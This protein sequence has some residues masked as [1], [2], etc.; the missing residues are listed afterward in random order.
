MRC[1]GVEWIPTRGDHQQTKTG[2]EAPQAVRIGNSSPASRRPRNQLI[3][4]VGGCVAS[5][6]ISKLQRD[7]PLAILPLTKPKR[8]LPHQKLDY[9]IF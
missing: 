5:H 2:H 9:G 1:D 4:L 6:F 7:H 8:P 3:N